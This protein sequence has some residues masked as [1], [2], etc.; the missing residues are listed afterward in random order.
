MSRA[1]RFLKAAQTEFSKIFLTLCDTKSSWQVWSDFVDLAAISIQNTVDK[2]ELRA[3]REARYVEIMKG[4]R[5]AEQKL[6]P[7][8][9]AIT[10]SALDEEPDQDFLGEMYMGL[11]L[12]SHWHG[13]FFT[14]YNI[15]KMM[16]EISASDLKAK[17]D[18]Q[19]WVGVMDP[20]C[21]A[22][23][24]LIAAR[25]RFVNQGLGFR[26]T[27]FVGQDIDH[28]AGLMCYIQLSLLGCA[29]YV[30]IAD[31]LCNPSVGVT[32]LVPTIKEGQDYWFM[33]MF[34]DEVWQWRAKADYLFAL[35][36]REVQ[37]T[38]EPEP[39]PKE[40]PP[41]AEPAEHIEPDEEPEPEQKNEYETEGNG[42][43][44]LF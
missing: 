21:G 1:V 24:T 31:S 4:Y 39:A 6:F 29:G 30:V 32:T 23:A 43:L 10:V 20:A 33:P 17:I 44:T 9:M 16:C 19:G 22:G 40:D 35:M 2:S 5:E 37:P 34:Y 27:L 7:E 36:G 15:C 11:D 18:S 12:G 42:Q 28:V 26:E 38:A 13:Q 25:N 3:K 41:P 14:P 8:L